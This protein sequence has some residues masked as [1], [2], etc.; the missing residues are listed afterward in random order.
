MVNIEKTNGCTM[1]GEEG[2]KGEGMVTEE[3]EVACETDRCAVMVERGRGNESV[4]RMVQ[5]RPRT[6]SNAGNEGKVAKVVAGHVWTLLIKP[7]I[8]CVCV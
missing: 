3:D 5:L 6:R 2:T 4:L 8:E 1:E 7:R